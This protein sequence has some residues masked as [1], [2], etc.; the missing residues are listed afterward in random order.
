VASRFGASYD[1][2]EDPTTT[3]YYVDVFTGLFRHLKLP[4]FHVI[5]HHAGSSIALEI[6]A[7][8]PDEVF[9]CCLSS[10]AMATAEEQA[11]MFKTLASEWNK[12]KEDGSHLMKVWNT[13]NGQLWTDL[14]IKNHEVIDTLRA[15]KGRDQAYAC[16]FKQDKLSYYNQIKCPVLAMCSKEDVLWPNFHYCSELVRQMTFELT[17]HALI[18]VS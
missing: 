9:T 17:D 11:I 2:V 12:P 1:S 14:D 3:R 5:G 15:W 6:A 8:Y 16:T 4:K 13:M 18:G 10:P 7:V